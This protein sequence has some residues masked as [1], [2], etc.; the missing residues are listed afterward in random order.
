MQAGTDHR[1][2]CKYN[3]TFKYKSSIYI[4]C[5]L[6]RN[7]YIVFF[8]LDPGTIMQF[9]VSFNNKLLCMMVK[10]VLPVLPRERCT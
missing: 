10:R 7:L 5:M 2:T 4:I 1:Y 6:P 9:N 3:V 8:V